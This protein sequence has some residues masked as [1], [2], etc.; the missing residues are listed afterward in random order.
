MLERFKESP[1]DKYVILITLFGLAIV[2]LTYILIFMPI[3]VAVP[4]YGILDYEFAWT[5]EKV[6]IIFSV[7][8]A[9]G[10]NRQISAIY[11]DFLYIIGYVSLALGLIFLV[12][13]RSEGKIR[14]LGLYFTLT[15]FLTGIFD[16]IENINL[17]IMLSTPIS[18][19]T[20]NPFIAS[21]SALIKFIF[22]FSA[23]A[24][25]II[26]IIILVINRVRK[27]EKK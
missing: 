27:H 20:I 26:A 5:P 18:I 17:L 14:T 4:T 22:L 16:I 13:R 11:W 15:P 19:S 2:I 23:I 3:E 25:F 10:I 24:Y 9:D 7:W 12:L 21:L 1:K 6:G 8:G